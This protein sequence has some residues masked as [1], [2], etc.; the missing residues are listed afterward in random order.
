[1]DSEHI[2]TGILLQMAAELGVNISISF[3]VKHFS[4]KSLQSCLNYIERLAKN[5]LPDT[6]EQE[7]RKR[8]FQ[9]FKKEIKPVD[10]I[11]ELLNQIKM[12]FCVAS[13][14][15]TEKII[16][17]LTATNLI[18]KFEGNIFSAYEIGSWKPNPDIFLYAAEKMGFKP[19]ECVVIEDSIA[20]V[21]AARRG[22]FDVY[23]YTGIE[24]K[25]EFEEEGA[26]VFHAMENLLELLR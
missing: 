5:G 9:V 21:Q 22:Q 18:Q 6:F 17:N 16:L 24:N 26:I 15:P 11:P 12:P 14:G 23:A 7:Y 8:T 2:S 20:G 10:G 13:S 25:F 3:A 19:N 1:V 4:G